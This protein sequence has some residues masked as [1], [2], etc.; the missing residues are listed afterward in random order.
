MLVALL[1]NGAHVSNRTDFF[2]F[3]ITHHASKWCNSSA[4]CLLLDRRADAN[5]DNSVGM[6]PLHIAAARGDRSVIAVLLA[7]RANV[8]ARLSADG[9]AYGAAYLLTG[10]TALQVATAA[11]HETAA[12]LLL[13]GCMNNRFPVGL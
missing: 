6:R 4:L 9:K 1:A 2:D 10:R 12:A 13:R 3:D 5:A 8:D 7:H 11:G